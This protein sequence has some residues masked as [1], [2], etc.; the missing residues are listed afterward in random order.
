MT[1]LFRFNADTNVP[2]SLIVEKCIFSGSNAGIKINATDRA[3][4]AYTNISFA[5][6]YKTSEFVENR[7][8]RLFVDF[9]P[10]TGTANELFT[11]PVAGNFSI[12]AGAGFAGASE[13]GD[14]RW[15]K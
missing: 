7:T 1:Q 14:P 8:D 3:N 11:D 2:G 13:A 15:F 9:I 12:K 10:Y 6:S 4:T 5:N